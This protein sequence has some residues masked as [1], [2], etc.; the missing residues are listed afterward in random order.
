MG[1]VPGKKWAHLCA[2]LLSDF[3]QLWR[4]KI[5]RM[6]QKGVSLLDEL[7]LL[8]SQIIYSLSHLPLVCRHILLKLDLVLDKAV[9]L[10]NKG[11]VLLELVLLG[12]K[13]L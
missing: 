3:W 11:S 9:V 10:S 12:L 7:E 5:R 1:L 8:G 4:R 13:F 6:Q 2:T